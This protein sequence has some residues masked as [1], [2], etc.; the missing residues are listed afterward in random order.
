MHTNKKFILI[1]LILW[2]KGSLLYDSVLKKVILLYLKCERH[3]LHSIYSSS[4]VNK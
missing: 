2:F 3:I 4:N 1:H